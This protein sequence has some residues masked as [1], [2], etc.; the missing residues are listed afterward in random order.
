[1]QH[2]NPAGATDFWFSARKA[3]SLMER[4]A[5]RTARNELGIGFTQYLV[6][7]VVDDRP[8]EFNQQAVADRL[9]LTKGTVSRQLELASAAGLL[10]RSPSP[11]SRRDW[12]ISL[13]RKGR[14][15]VRLGAQTLPEA[16]GRVFAE[17]DDAELRTSIDLLHRLVDRLDA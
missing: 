17:V 6:L 14:E 16:Q 10:V 11:T 7:S 2:A 9:G 13:T 4:I 3:V 1:M 15:L 12:L 8:G 5:D